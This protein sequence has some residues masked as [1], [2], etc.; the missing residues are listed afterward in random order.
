MCIGTLKF[1][2]HAAGKRLL[3]LIFGSV[4]ANAILYSI[5][6]YANLVRTGLGFIPTWTGRYHNPL[7]NGV[8]II[9]TF[10]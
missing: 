7:R 3:R 2:I 9:Y 6:P 4:G 8:V 1:D 10:F 5:T